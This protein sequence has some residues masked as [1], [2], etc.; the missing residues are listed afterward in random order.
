MGTWF[1]EYIYIPLGGNRVTRLKWIRNIA[2]VWFV[3]GLWH[4]AAW[5]FIFWGL[6]FGVVLTAE[7][8]WLEKWLIKI[9]AVLR[10]IYTLTVVTFSFVIFLI[11]DGQM[12][13]EYFRGMTGLLPGV[14]PLTGESLY[15]LR[16]YGFVLLLA[17]F[18]ATP[19]LRNLFAKLRTDDKLNA[20]IDYITPAFNAVLLIIS[21]AYLVDD[22]FNPFLYFRF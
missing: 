6:Y 8:L 17:V 11:E 10:H 19:V 5:N 4:G 9:P 12:I 22:S 13:G 14:P 21:A 18:G 1:R 3:T 2:V 7:K 15:Y 16:S 20:A